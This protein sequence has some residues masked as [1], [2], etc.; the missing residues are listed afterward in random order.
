MDFLSTFLT[1]RDLNMLFSM[2]FLSSGGYAIGTLE[3]YEL[4]LFK[5]VQELNLVAVSVE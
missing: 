2:F 5:F 4:L 1:K 3:S